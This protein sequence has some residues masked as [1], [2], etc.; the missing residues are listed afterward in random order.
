MAEKHL[1]GP[2]APAFRGDWG[3]GAVF[4][5]RDVR[6]PAHEAYPCHCR[7]IIIQFQVFVLT[8]FI[9]RVQTYNFK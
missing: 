7:I 2:R 9:W 1:A 5:G 8:G 6:P 3:R 4:D